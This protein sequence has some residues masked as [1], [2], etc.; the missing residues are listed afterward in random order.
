MKNYFHEW[1][2]GNHENRGVLWRKNGR[3]M[4]LV[5]LMEEGE[6]RIFA[7]VFSHE[8]SII[9]KC[10]MGIVGK[11]LDRGMRPSRVFKR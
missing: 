2:K 6:K 8:I 7:A 5:F 11:I 1:K 4:R 9:P 10:K 3:K